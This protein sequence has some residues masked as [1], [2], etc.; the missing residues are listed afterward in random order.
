M[1]DSKRLLTMFAAGI[2]A[3]SV[4]FSTAQAVAQQQD[5][6]TD[7]WTVGTGDY[8]LQDGVPG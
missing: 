8:I 2:V 1:Q 7:S 6:V 3:L 4:L 5:S